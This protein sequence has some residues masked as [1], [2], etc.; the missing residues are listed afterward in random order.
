MIMTGELETVITEKKENETKMNEDI[1][2][3]NKIN[4]K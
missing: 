2:N 4:D 3:L 1:N